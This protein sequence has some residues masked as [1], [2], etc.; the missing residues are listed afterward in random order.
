VQLVPCLQL[1]ES[2][3]LLSRLIP[4]KVLCNEWY[5]HMYPLPSHFMCLVIA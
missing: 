5:F 1:K 3:E 4:P 2:S